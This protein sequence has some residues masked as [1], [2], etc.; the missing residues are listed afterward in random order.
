MLIKRVVPTS[1]GHVHKSDP[2]FVLINYQKIVMKSNPP[3][4][5]PHKNLT[6]TKDIMV[7][8]FT[9][10]GLMKSAC[11]FVGGKYAFSLIKL[12]NSDLLL[13]RDEIRLNKYDTFNVSVQDKPLLLHNTRYKINK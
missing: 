5:P 7:I 11:K 8:F 2:I 3:P 4:P 12:E 9:S 10:L 13:Y 1:H 6:P